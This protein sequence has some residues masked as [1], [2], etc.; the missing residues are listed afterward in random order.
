MTDDALL[1]ALALPLD[2]FLEALLDD[3]PRTP[4]RELQAAAQAAGKACTKA[5]AKKIRD[6]WALR[7]EGGAPPPDGEEE[8]EASGQAPSLEEVARRF[9]ECTLA[10]DARSAESWGRTYARMLSILPDGAG[11]AEDGVSYAALS[12]AERACMLALVQKAAG[13]MPD[14][15]GMWWIGMIARVPAPAERAHPAHTPLP[16]AGRPAK[17][18]VA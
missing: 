16:E 8:A 11:K 18:V 14:E 12:E 3:A 13:A 7:R 9:A 2:G 10:G 6:R 1:L 17:V 4:A 5:Q 15:D